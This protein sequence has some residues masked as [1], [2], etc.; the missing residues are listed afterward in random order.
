[1]IR[2]GM[3]AVWTMMSLVLQVG[4]F[5]QK[6][7]ERE[8]DLIQLARLESKVLR[9]SKPGKAFTANVTGQ[10]DCNLTRYIYLGSLKCEDGH[11]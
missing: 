7:P 3:I 8:T 2:F 10:K 9:K 11:N 5:G 1:M 4:A 6:P